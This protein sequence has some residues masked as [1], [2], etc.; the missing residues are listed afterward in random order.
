MHLAMYVTAQG[1]RDRAQ[2][3][4]PHHLARIR[5]AIT[6]HDAGHRLTVK[7][8]DLVDHLDVIAAGH[9]AEPV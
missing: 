8:F 9:W 3:R 6:T 2:S 5:F 7:D 4:Y 1:L